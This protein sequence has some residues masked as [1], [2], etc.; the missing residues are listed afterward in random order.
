M[1]EA[2]YG[3]TSEAAFT[4]RSATLPQ[5]PLYFESLASL[6]GIILSCPCGGPS[7]YS[8]DHA[9]ENREACPRRCGYECAPGCERDTPSS[10]SCGGGDCPVPRR[11]RWT[12][13]ACR[14]ETSG[15]FPDW[16]T[17]ACSGPSLR[18]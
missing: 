14:R 18:P 16:R 5:I 4:L 17:E 10:A 1:G 15:P 2:P 7:G 13:A 9:S 8:C 3:K 12:A 11:W 6:P